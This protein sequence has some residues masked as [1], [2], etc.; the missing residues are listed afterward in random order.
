LEL[1]YVKGVPKNDGL[2]SAIGGLKIAIL[3]GCPLIGLYE[4]RPVESK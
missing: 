1:D 2:A 4:L 3:E